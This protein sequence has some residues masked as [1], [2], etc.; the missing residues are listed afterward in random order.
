VVTVDDRINKTETLNC[1]GVS[2]ESIPVWT[3]QGNGIQA[4]SIDLSY[5][6][7][8]DFR[9]L[10]KFTALHTLIIDRAGLESITPLPPL[11]NLVA[12]SLGRNK[13]H[14]L[15][16][17]L[18]GLRLKFPGLT[19]LHLLG[20]PF[21]PDGEP[22]VA[23]EEAY[24]KLRAL[25][26]MSIPELQVLDGRTTDWASEPVRP[27][28]VDTYD[29][30]LC[31]EAVALAEHGDFLVCKASATVH[32]LIVND[33]G[34]ATL[35][36]IHLD[37]SLRYVFDGRLHGSL[38][39]ILLH[40][41]ATPLKGARGQDII[42]RAA[43]ATDH[44]TDAQVKPE[45]AAVA[46]AAAAAAKQQQKPDQ[47]G[48]KAASA[49]SALPQPAPKVPDPLPWLL[50]TEVAVAASKG[51]LL[52]ILFGDG[53]PDFWERLYTKNKYTETSLEAWSGAKRRKVMY[54]IPRKGLQPKTAVV[55]AHHLAIDC[56]TFTVVD[57][58]TST[59]GAPF[60]TSFSSSVQWVL[61][62]LGNGSTQIDTSGGVTWLKSCS[63]KGT[64]T[65]SIKKAM[66]SSFQQIIKELHTYVEGKQLQRHNTLKSY[67]VL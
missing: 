62:D 37:G 46:E 13:I 31:V 7:I 36:D 6:S 16:R 55:E 45:A 39:D 22:G 24:E 28:Y 4:K 58:C 52:N 51:A 40:H 2:N 32:E 66:G 43:A 15:H 38:E 19:H 26:T 44:L 3:M 56:A 57:V 29:S 59:P 67:E 30:D 1:R 34:K 60:G 54:T 23:Q 42:L 65:R 27:W 49:A 9:L 17:L 47:A 53:A 63:L 11:P 25:V 5:S 41:G 61:R 48:G 8:Q 35:F 10:A 14:V 12:L 20:N 21:Y 50:V 18:K 64:I 33:N